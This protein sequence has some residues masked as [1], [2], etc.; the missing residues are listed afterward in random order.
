MKTTFLQIAFVLLSIPG[1]AQSNGSGSYEELMARSRK[2]RTTAIVMVSTGPVIAV[3]GIGTLIYGIIQNE[4][5]DF[6]YYVD[7]N[8][9]YIQGP[10]KKYT[11]EI[12]V[13][14]AATVIGLGVALGSIAF[15]NKANELKSEARKMKLKTSVDR[16]NIPGMQTNFSNARITQYKLSLVIPLGS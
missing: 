16:F 6:E 10:Q 11:T 14:A 2:A 15:T 7:A 5:G 9:N 3:G 4:S 13:G 12:V 1:F 8:G